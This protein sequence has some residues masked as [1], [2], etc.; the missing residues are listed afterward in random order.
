MLQSKVNALKVKPALEYLRGLSD[1]KGAPR[2]SV[3]Y[4]TAVNGFDSVLYGNAQS[5]AAEYGSVLDDLFDVLGLNEGTSSVV[6]R[7]QLG[8]LG[9]FADSVENAL[10]TGR[11]ACGAGSE[12]GYACGFRFCLNSR[13]IVL[14]GNDDYLADALAGLKSLHGNA[15]D[16]ALAKREQYLVY[17]AHSGGVSCAN[18]NN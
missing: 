12:L 17:S 15:Y 4:K 16:L 8:V 5:R 18:Y 10:L 11:A 9:Y 1:V 7:Y 2:R 6:Y 14:T 13:D 3:D